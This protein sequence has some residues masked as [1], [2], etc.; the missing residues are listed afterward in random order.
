[1]TQQ[2]LSLI[3]NTPLVKVSKLNTGL[4]ELYLKLECQNPGG[5]IKDRIGLSM[6]EDAENRSLI[7]PGYTL[8]EATAGNTGIG[9]ALVALCKGYKMILVVPDKMSVEKI[10]LI[11][12]MGAE[13]ILTRSDV[14]K[15]HPDYY[16]DKAKQIAKETK[17]SYYID[18]FSNA[19][20]PLAH[21]KT[22]GPEILS[23]MNG[24]VDAIICGVGSGGTITGLSN[25]FAKTLP[26]CEM[27]VADPIGSIIAPYVNSGNI[28]KEVG[29][30]I[31]EGIGEDFL[32]PLLD[33]TRV[34]KAYSISDRES[35]SS[36][37]QLLLSNGIL[38]GSSSGTLIAAA[39]KYCQ[40]QT[41]AKRVV[42]FVCDSG[43][44]YISKVFSQSFSKEEG[45]TPREQ[46]GDLRDYVFCSFK[47]GSTIY[48][49]PN[50]SLKIAFTRMKMFNLSQ[51]PVLDGKKVVGVIDES[52]ILT[53]IVSD[54]NKFDSLVSESMTS[55]PIIL[56]PSDTIETVLSLFKI[57]MVGILVEDDDFYGVITR[58]DVVNALRL[59]NQQLAKILKT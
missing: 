21:E 41:T 52:D 14:G 31:V 27:V 13:V 17:N 5:S 8:V 42:T 4:C 57:G 43:N 30:W 23:Q 36:A 33:L 51:L 25:F 54:Y 24:N 38:G 1:M 46:K 49:Q 53:Q 40:E 16:Q 47:E 2:V 15:G 39:L 6:I 20:N 28:P 26:N 29:S 58:T 22:T 10:S 3:G 34:K 59:K 32:P 45:L 18:Q 7:K 35:F 44:R 11:K 19:A 56:K 48:V 50:E 37:Q 12:A 9:L 55:N